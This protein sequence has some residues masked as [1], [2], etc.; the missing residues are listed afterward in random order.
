[1][2]LGVASQFACTL[3]RN[4]AFHCKVLRG[5]DTP[6]TLLPR[7]RGQGSILGGRRG[8]G[9]SVPSPPFLAQEGV[10]TP[11]PF[12]FKSKPGWCRIGSAPRTG[13]SPGPIVFTS[14][15]IATAH[16]AGPA[17]ESLRIRVLDA[18]T[19]NHSKHLV[20]VLRRPSVGRRGEQVRSRRTLASTSD[21][22]HTRQ[23]VWLQ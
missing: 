18:H 15:I 20:Y 8:F 19:S 16:E 12:A 4:D 6:H 9:G 22:L 11:P 3:D 17:A 5:F 23:E 14:A 13:L 21:V 2:I 7:T 10:W 1:M